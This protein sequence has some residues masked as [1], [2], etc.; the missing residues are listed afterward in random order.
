MESVKPGKLEVSEA[1]ET[2]P[3]LR[4]VGTTQDTTPGH[5]ASSWRLASSITSNPLK[6]RFG[7][8][9]FSVEAPSI[10]TEAS[11]PW[12]KQ[13]WKC[14][15]SKPGATLESDWKWDFTVDWTINSARAH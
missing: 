7:P 8:A 12:T 1:S 9:V 6:E 4:P 11:Q 3:S 5:A 10:R 14:I 2:R 13:S 15:L